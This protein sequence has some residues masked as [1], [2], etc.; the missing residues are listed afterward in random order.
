M[1]QT[2][3]VTAL[4][5]TGRD[6]VTVVLDG[7]P[8]LVLSGAAAYQL[9]LRRG[10]TVDADLWRRAQT[11]AE[12]EA[13]EASAARRLAAR[14]ATKADLRRRLLQRFAPEAV[15]AALGHLQSIGALEDDATFAR[16]WLGSAAA[17]G[18][19]AR[20][21]LAALLRK[22]VAV[23][24]ARGAVAEA[25][26]DSD[27]SAVAVAVARAALRRY[28]ALPHEQA[29]RRLW[30]FLARRGFSPADAS[31]AV[32]TVLGDEPAGED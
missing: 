3:R 27:E 21:R 26:G 18:L 23:D 20:A 7:Q 32:R 13:A 14:P 25:A 6:R 5:A 10:A 11:R 15:D 19:G 31:R 8:A 1:G 22:G 9:G 16:R 28:A 2:A 12:T 4:R 30:A 29:A 17:A 24:V